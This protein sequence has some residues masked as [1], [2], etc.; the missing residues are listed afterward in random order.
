M[1][2]LEFIHCQQLLGVDT[3]LRPLIETPKTLAPSTP[4]W[5]ETKRDRWDL[6]SA[7]DPSAPDPVDEEDNYGT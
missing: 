2:I 1:A 6:D 7:W 4:P 3:L 5:D